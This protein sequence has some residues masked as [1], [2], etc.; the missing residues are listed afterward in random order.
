M[1]MQDKEFD[2]V[3]SS[4]FEQFEAEP[5]PMIWANIA[6]KLDG[7][8]SKRLWIPYLS[9]AAGIVVVFTAGLLF[10]HHTEP[11]QHHNYAN[12]IHRDTVKTAGPV[13]ATPIVKQPEPVKVDKTSAEKI[14]V[15]K[16]NR[17][18]TSFPANKIAVMNKA[19]DLIKDEQTDTARVRLIAQ[20]SVPAGIPLK[21][22][23]IMPDV[24][25]TPKAVDVVV[26]A[27]VEKAAVTALADKQDAGAEKKHRIHSLG[28]L[29]NILVA[30]VDKRQDKLIEF[31]DSDDDDAE[32]NVT[33]INLGLIKLGKH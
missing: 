9:I 3:F 13:D 8:K 29:I 14:A 1:D 25:L 23:P 12:M 11:E 2:E 5:S 31:S 18:R 4:K 17:R 22:R 15:N 19:D 7:E 30:K 32:S 20:T 33:G 21:V 10:L 27:P 24:Q 16:T 6:G 26:S 28:D